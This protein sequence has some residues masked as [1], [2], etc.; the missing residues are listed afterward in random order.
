MTETEKPPR[1][2]ALCPGSRRPTAKLLV[3]NLQL[4]QEV[5]HGGTVGRTA[6]LGDT[7]A[8]GGDG[9]HEVGGRE[10]SGDCAVGAG[11]DAHRSRIHQM[12]DG[13]IPKNPLPREAGVLVF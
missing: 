7:A 4:V 3:V 2:A 10:A 9:P 12:V 5:D 11:V 6:G 13:S 1:R 8:E